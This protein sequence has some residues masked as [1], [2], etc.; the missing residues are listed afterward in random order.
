MVVVL[1]Q[2]KNIGNGEKW[3][4]VY[5]WMIEKTNEILCDLFVYIILG[6]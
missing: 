4:R 1:I 6:K 5:C 2:K 3:Q